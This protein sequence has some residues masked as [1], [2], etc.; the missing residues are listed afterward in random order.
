MCVLCVCVCV[1][2][3]GE[4]GGGG[5]RGGGFNDAGHTKEK[6][7]PILI[8]IVSK[9]ASPSFEF[10]PTFDTICYI[11]RMGCIPLLLGLLTQHSQQ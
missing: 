10:S 7:H 3:C 8:L 2:V 9:K 1:C 4:G 5:G 11:L 6:V